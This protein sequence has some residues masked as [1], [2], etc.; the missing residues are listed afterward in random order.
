M[1]WMR[2]AIAGVLLLTVTGGG[3]VAEESMRT[4]TYPLGR[5]RWRGRIRFPVPRRCR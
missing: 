5:R 1:S 3:L 2:G 4:L